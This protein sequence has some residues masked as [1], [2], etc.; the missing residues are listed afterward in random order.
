MTTTTIE[1]RIDEARA[2]GDSQLLRDLI[3]EREDPFWRGVNRAL[4]G[5][6]LTEGQRWV[7]QCE[8]DNVLDLFRGSDGP[9]V[10]AEDL[11]LIGERFTRGILSEPLRIKVLRGMY[12][13]HRVQDT[14]PVDDGIVG[15]AVD[16]AVETLKP[17][18][19]GWNGPSI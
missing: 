15:R 3:A 8:V 5:V 18:M 11:E 4:A 19:Q 14:V 2:A 6:R 17:Y 12:A 16:E 1:A 9:K 7:V 10:S 13:E